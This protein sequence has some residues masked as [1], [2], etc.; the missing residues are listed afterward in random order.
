[1]PARTLPGWHREKGTGRG[2]IGPDGERLSRRQ[3]D[4]MAHAVA[5]KGAVAPERVAKNVAGLRRYNRLVSA[6]VELERSRGEKA[7]RKT[8]RES[9]VFK[10]AVRDLKTAKGPGNGAMNQRREA[11]KTIG[12]RNKIPDWVPVGLSN[13]YRQG[14][15]RKTSAVLRRFE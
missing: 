9:A 6:R 14:K 10:Q 1:M 11:L 4:A 8:V 5:G 2:Y 3:Y 13:R 12:L 15:L 7:T